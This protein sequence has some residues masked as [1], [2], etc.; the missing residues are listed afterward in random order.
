MTDIKS[1][2]L[3]AQFFAGPGRLAAQGVVDASSTENTAFPVA[4]KLRDAAGKTHRVW[5][6]SDEVKSHIE[7]LVDE[8]ATVK[9]CRDRELANDNDNL[10]GMFGDVYRDTIPVGHEEFGNPYS[11]R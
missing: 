4:V 6:A 2:D 10:W 5:V 3:N 7:K 11:S 9:V 1:G 8:G